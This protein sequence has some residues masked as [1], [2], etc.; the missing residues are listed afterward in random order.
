LTEEKNDGSYGK[1]VINL[2]KS[3]GYII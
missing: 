1:V 3:I 2:I